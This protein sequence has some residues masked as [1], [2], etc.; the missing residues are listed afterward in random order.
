MGGMTAI[1]PLCCLPLAAVVLLVACGQPAPPPPADRPS[2]GGTAVIGVLGDVHNW[3]PY[4]ADSAFSENLLAL[5]YPSLAVEQ[6][7]YRDHPPSFEPALA[8]SWEWSEDRL[9]LTFHLRDDAEWSDGVPVTS[10]DVVFSWRAQVAEAIAWPGV[11][12]KEAIAAVEARDEHT[13]DFRFTRAYPYQL[14]DAN[15]GLIIPAHAWSSIPFESWEETDWSSLGLA[16]GPFRLAR[17]TPNQEI[18][19]EAN[20][21]YWDPTRP[22]LE[23]VVFRVVP[24]PTGLNTQ[25]RSGA[26]DFVENVPTADAERL[27][28]DPRT[29]VVVYPDRSYA[30]VA[31]NNDHPVLRDARVRRALTLAIDRRTILQTVRRGF[32]RLAAGPVLSGMWAFN[33]ELEPLPFD[34]EA[35]APCSP[36]RVSPTA[37]GTASSTARGRRSSSSS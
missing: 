14:M 7:D 13:V 10:A 26:L 24:D 33:H 16:A 18:V 19:L 30:F 12:D 28:D 35:P 36:R 17:H 37:T 25:F 3:N 32:G 31:W 9:T 4:L 27:R 11:F 8:S 2:R 23:R 34:P 22:L 5:I 6:A 15:E 29:T 1:K 21:A 20:P